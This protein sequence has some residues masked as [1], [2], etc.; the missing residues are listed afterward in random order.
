MR[1]L[2][3]ICLL[4]SLSLWLSNC[5]RGS[6]K[7]AATEFALVIQE[8]L[9]VLGPAK[10]TLSAGDAGNRFGLTVNR[11]EGVVDGRWHFN[12]R[13]TIEVGNCDAVRRS[14]SPDPMPLRSPV[15]SCP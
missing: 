2:C 10:V 4:F 14:D 7:Q 15:S 5:M 3:E 6:A 8:A 11:D 12:L 1:S 9:N 13:M